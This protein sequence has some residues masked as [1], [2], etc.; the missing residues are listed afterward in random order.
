QRAFFPANERL[1]VSGTNWVFGTRNFLLKNSN[2]LHTPW[3]ADTA[4]NLSCELDTIVQQFIFGNPDS[5]R[6]YRLSNND[7]I[8]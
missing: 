1:R 4:L 6:I 5:V 8:L 3:L 7:S 2:Q